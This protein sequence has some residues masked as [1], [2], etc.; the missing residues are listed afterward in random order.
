MAGHHHSAVPL[1]VGIV[2]MLTVVMMVSVTAVG[3]P[4]VRPVHRGSTFVYFEVRHSA[5]YWT[6]KRMRTARPVH[7]V[8]NH[9]SSDNNDNS[10]KASDGDSTHTYL[11]RA[12]KPVCSGATATLLQSTYD[13]VQAPLFT[14]G[15]VF[16]RSQDDKPYV[17]SGSIAE[18]SR[19]VWTAAHCVFNISVTN[20]TVAGMISNFVFVPQ[21]H[22]GTAN[23]GRYSAT[24]IHVSGGWM[25]LHDRAYDFALAEFA[26]PFRASYGHVTLYTGPLVAKKPLVRGYGYPNADP[27]NGMWVNVCQSVACM[28]DKYISPA[29]LGFSCTSTAGSSGGPMLLVTDGSYPDEVIVDSSQNTVPIVNND[30]TRVNLMVGL[31]SY[32]YAEDRE[33]IFSPFFGDQVRQF[34]DDV[35]RNV[36]ERSTAARC[37]YA[38]I[39]SILSTLDWQISITAFLR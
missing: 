33:L 25:D 20:G 9:N 27:F 2:V 1:V 36:A 34:F 37:C 4:P 21:F 13:Y 17:C 19:L 8:H 18:G 26:K 31:I 14:V 38:A 7:S 10:D 11:R 23:L 35:L 12:E 39:L 16:F 28:R 5:G 6:E 29:S 24:R 22:N 15:K 30:G 32:V 3:P